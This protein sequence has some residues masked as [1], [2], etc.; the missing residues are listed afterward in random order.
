MSRNSINKVKFDIQDMKQRSLANQCD[1]LVVYWHHQ[2][3]EIDKAEEQRKQEA[4]RA[5]KERI[6]QEKEEEERA[7]EAAS[8]PRNSTSKPKI[9]LGMNAIL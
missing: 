7:K 9:S 5:E 3:Y 2:Q 6:Q 4:I 1:N 8:K